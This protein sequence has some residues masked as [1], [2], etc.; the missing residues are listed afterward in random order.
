MGVT[1]A[2]LAGGALAAQPM[3]LPL[4]VGLAM[5]SGFGWYSLSGILITEAYCP[6][7]GSVAFF[8]E[9]ARELVAIMLIPTLVRQSSC[10][11]LGLCGTNSMDITLPMLQRRGGLGIFPR[12]SAWLSA[13]L[14]GT[15]ANSLVLLKSAKGIEH[16]F[17]I[18]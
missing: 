17:D 10:S 1:L 14:G 5:A 18:P 11:A 9:L 4:K 6:V 7:L 15:R 16:N 3:K 2:S 13:E 12:H 8:N